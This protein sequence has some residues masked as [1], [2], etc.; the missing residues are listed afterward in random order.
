MKQ[1]SRVV[2]SEGMHLAQHHFQAQS[3]YFEDA[4]HFAVAQLHYRAY[5]LAGI[6]LDADALLRMSDRALYFAKSRGRNRVE[7]VE[8]AGELAPPGTPAPDSPTDVPR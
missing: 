3:R 2:W 7:V 5:G 4:I 6:T 1:L 8:S